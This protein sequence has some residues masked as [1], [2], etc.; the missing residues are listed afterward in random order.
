MDS[1]YIKRALTEGSPSPRYATRGTGLVVAAGTLAMI[2][3]L[4]VG[5]N[6]AVAQTAPDSRPHRYL[7]VSTTETVRSLQLPVGARATALRYPHVGAVVAD[8]TAAQATDLDR[9]AGVTVARDGLVHAMPVSE[10]AANRP[11][12]TGGGQSPQAAASSWGLD[13]VDQR[14]LPLSGTYTPHLGVDGHGVDAFIIDTGLAAGHPE[15]TGRVGNGIDIVAGD[16]DPQDCNGHG[17]HVA[18]TIGSSQYG[19]AAKTILHG[20]RVLDCDGGGSLSDVIAG[21]DWV[22]QQRIALGRPVVANM[23]LGGGLNAALNDATSNMVRNDVV[24]V[25]AAGNS[26]DDACNQS[27]ASTPEAV[28]VAASGRDDSHAW[29]SNFGSCVDLYAPGVDIVS[30]DAFDP[31]GETTMS[32]TSMASPHVAGWA[33]LFMSLHPDATPELTVQ[34]LLDSGSSDKIV[35]APA[36]TANVLPYTQQMIIRTTAMLSTVTNTALR[37]DIDPNGVEVDYTV[38]GQRRRDGAWVTQWTLS[39]SGDQ[40]TLQREVP[41]GWWRVLVPAQHGQPR[42]LSNAVRIAR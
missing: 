15:F 12:S 9:Q 38:R 33:A 27:P 20:V 18:G 30:T 28:T 13:R 40:E 23:S 24:T 6:T 7:V 1:H 34:A 31:N 10:D 35:G 39:T 11:R 19:V 8:L 21:M 29:F 5:G 3:G 17:T 14:G 42:A 16:A 41:S 4:P 2:A 22:V 36:G 37:A 25:V 26:A 32:G